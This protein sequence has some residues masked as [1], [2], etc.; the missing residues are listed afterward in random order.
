MREERSPA[1]SLQ[2][3]FRNKFLQLVGRH[4]H[5]VQ[6]V[7][8]GIIPRLS[9]DPGACLP[10]APRTPATGVGV[11]RLRGGRSPVLE[12]H[13]CQA[14][15]GLRWRRIIVGEREGGKK[16]SGTLRQNY[17]FFIDGTYIDFKGIACS[18]FSPNINRTHTKH[19]LSLR[20]FCPM[21]K[22]KNIRRFPIGTG[23]LAPIVLRAPRLHFDWKTHARPT[24]AQ[25][26][27]HRLKR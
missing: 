23:P 27:P 19:Q 16:N 8:S 20:K 25:S 2:I 4:G 9:I 7:D 1:S 17:F 26:I 22:R 12:I 13:Q 15:S 5:F 10:E 6:T 24:H 3:S 14:F 21:I 11:R 18:L